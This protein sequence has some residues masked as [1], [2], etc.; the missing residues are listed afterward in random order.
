MNSL[1]SR[2]VLYVLIP[3]FLLALCLTLAAAGQT[4]TSPGLPLGKPGLKET[5]TTEQ[6]SA[7]V[8][9]TR[10]VRGQQSK[11]DFYTVDVAFRGDRAAAEELAARLRAD[12]Y[13][14]V[15]VEV[16]ERAPDDP[17][18]GPLGYL[19][20]VGS[21]ATEAGADDLRAVLTA[22]GYTG[23]RTVYT[24]EDGGESTGPWV[25]H[26]LKADPDRYRGTLAPKLATGIVPDREPLT[27]I[28]ART[29]SLAAVNG[30]YFVI[31]ETDG[32]PGDLAGISVLEGDLVSEA[33]D[34]RTSLVLPKGDGAGADVAAISDDFTATSSDGA[35]REVDGLNRKPGLI[36]ACG[37]DGGD[38]PTELPKHDFTCTDPSE[39]I[40]FTPI[41]GPSTEP[42]EGAEAVLDASGRVVG[43][44]YGRGGQI[45]DHGSVLSGTG[46]GADWLSAHAQPG[47]KVQ[48]ET[49]FQ[50][51]GASL[52]GKTGVV[53]GGPRLLRGGNPA[54]TAYAEGF[55][56]PEDPEFYYRFGIRRN[57][58]TMAGV[59]PGG[60]L[61]LVAVDGRKPGYSVGAS[62]RE[63]AA[64]ME[65]LGAEE[66]VNLDGGGS[67]TMTLGTR[68]VTRPSDATGERPIGDA[69]VLLH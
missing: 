58:R 8:T 16:I 61:L 39:L 33:V 52:A 51:G 10:I 47:T 3:L 63:E 36:R 65:S 22:K 4:L 69:V 26:V 62:F 14:P 53:N 45:P 66:A 43:L 2:S 18:G 37:G 31:G 21:F 29:D 12:G 27:S 41:F 6:I 30:G 40:L 7:G 56:Y 23:L 24:G 34:G 11:K 67:T 50:T 28:S 55:V 20:R 32:T 68:L 54:I 48:I 60:D 15:I 38:T 46:D 17:Q 1:R 9:Y 42:G 59:T 5:R 13:E 44:R 25:V 57:P 35:G 49:R 19:V 64:I